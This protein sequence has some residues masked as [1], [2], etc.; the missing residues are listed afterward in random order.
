M[1]AKKPTAQPQTDADRYRLQQAQA[2]IDWYRAQVAAGLSEEPA[3][4][5]KP[6]RWRGR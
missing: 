4:P 5:D 6:R 1:S 3:E 2:L